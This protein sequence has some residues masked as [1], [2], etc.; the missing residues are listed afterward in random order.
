MTNRD[1]ASQHGFK[2]NS[3]DPDN[4]ENHTGAASIWRKIE[5]ARRPT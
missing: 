3:Y 5:S 4:L 1:F 2:L